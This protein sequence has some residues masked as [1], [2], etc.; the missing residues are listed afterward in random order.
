MKHST[1]ILGDALTLALITLVG[2]ASHAEFTLS[3]IPRMAATFIPLCAGWFLLAP[4]LGLYQD[5]LVGS[6]SELW[7]PG[8]AMLFAGP[9]AALLRSMLLNTPVIPSFAVILTLTAALGLTLWRCAW[10]FLR[11]PQTWR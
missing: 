9:L 8:F 4:S 3:F 2:F 6:V 10:L 5:P 11:K 1:L 7:R